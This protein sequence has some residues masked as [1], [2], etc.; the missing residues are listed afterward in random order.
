M[1]MGFLR[2]AKWLC[3]INAMTAAPQLSEADHA[4]R[5]MSH[6]I[7]KQFDQEYYSNVESSSSFN[8]PTPQSQTGRDLEMTSIMQHARLSLQHMSV[9]STFRGY[10]KQQWREVQDSRNHPGLD[11]Q[12]TGAEVKSLAHLRLWRRLLADDIRKDGLDITEDD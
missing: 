10:A 3:S 6:G 11:L 4:G 8:N 7:W 5:S 9:F 12:G 1:D 2:S